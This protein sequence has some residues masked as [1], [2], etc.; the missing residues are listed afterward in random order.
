MTETLRAPHEV[1]FS[2][3]RSVGG[4]VGAFLH[5]L[6]RGQILGSRLADGRVIVPPVDADPE[7]GEPAVAL[8]RCNDHGRVT[9]WTWVEE[10][11]EEHVLDRPF[12]LALVQPA[13]A[14]TS[15][16]HCVDAGSPGRMRTGMTV[17]A[18]WREDR[19]G[20][21]LDIRAFVPSDADDTAPEA[22]TAPPRQSDGTEPDDAE[23]ADISVASDLRLLYTYEPGRALSGFLVGLSRGQII[24]GRCP[25]CGGVYVPPH[26]TCPACRTGPMTGIDLPDRGTISSYTVVHI[27]FH[28]MQIELPFVCAWI[29]L[30]GA[31]VPFAHLLG[32]TPLEEVAVGQPVEA[33]WA[34]ERDL[35]PTWEAIRYFRVARAPGGHGEKGI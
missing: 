11:S 23:S 4:A 22:A 7:T 19:T 8:V 25:E 26:S 31:S 30:D 17:R 2:Y 21:I 6:A 15:L 35:A 16:L 32:E 13:G 1:S 20:S 29:R 27:P 24:G 34:D 14:D 33:V 5:G 9:S 28:G 3:R 10:P 12:A 18:D